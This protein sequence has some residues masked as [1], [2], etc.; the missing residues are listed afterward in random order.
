M[1]ARVVGLLGVTAMVMGAVGITSRE[2]E[3]KW[4]LNYFS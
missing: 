4:V 2:G 3:D 1:D